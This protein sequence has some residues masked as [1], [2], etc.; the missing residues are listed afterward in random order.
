MK[1]I[2]VNLLIITLCIFMVS[3]T[4]WRSKKPPIHLNPNLDFQPKNTPQSDSLERPANVVP[5]GNEESFVTPE[6]R[7]QYLKED[8]EV[9]IGKTKAGAWVQKIPLEVSHQFVE[10]GQDR[11]NIYCTPCHGLDGSGIAPV[12]QRGWIRPAAYWDERIVNY[13]DGELY[14]IVKNG[15]RS[16]PGYK[17][18]LSASD[19]WAIVS[20]VRALQKTRLST[21]KDV[22]SELRNEILE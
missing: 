17:Q 1:K 5:W 8:T 6:E 19:R 12:T 20:Y 9:Y 2:L 13:T 18:Q 7:E 22:P 14:D 16:M 4:G 21:I 15:I 11:Y 3:C 10:R